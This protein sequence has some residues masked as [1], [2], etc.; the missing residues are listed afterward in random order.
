MI[1]LIPTPVPRIP[2][3]ISRIPIIPTLITRILI[4]PTMISCIPTLIPRITIIPLI[5]LSNFPFRLL[6][7][8]IPFKQ[9]ICF[10][11]INLTNNKLIPLFSLSKQT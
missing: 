3:M 4:I 10:L 1:P 9:I 7:I 2:T 5:L 6:Q 11:S 8:A